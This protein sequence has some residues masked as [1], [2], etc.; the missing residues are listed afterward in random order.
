MIRVAPT[1]DDPGDS[2][3]NLPVTTTVVHIDNPGGYDVYIGRANPRRGLAKSKWA[4]PFKINDER[5]RDWVIRAYHVW[6]LNHPEL[7]ADLHELRGKRLGCF[8][9]P[10][11]CHGDVLADLANAL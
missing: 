6:L 2:M 4:N 7:Y 5:D 9:A 3:E 10:K 11:P 1:P 8:C